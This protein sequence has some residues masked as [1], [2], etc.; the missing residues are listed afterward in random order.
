M[1]RNAQTEAPSLHQLMLVQPDGHADAAAVVRHASADAPA[2]GLSTDVAIEHWDDLFNAV[3]VRL[4]TA[5]VVPADDSANAQAA[6]MSTTVLECV[7]ALE[8]LHSTLAH[9]VDRRQRYEREAAAARAELA[10]ARAELAG[11]RASEEQ[12]R[13]QALHDSLTSL[14][15]RAYF[16]QR[17]KHAVIE[18][19]RG[20]SALA[21]LYLDL[22]GFKSINDL[23]G[24]ETG[25][26]VLRIVAARLV[27]AVRGEDMVS[28][29]GGDE[30][31]C[32]LVGMPSREQLSHLA[33]KLFD[34]VMAPLRIGELRLT[35]RPSIGI[36]TYPTDGCSAGAL[37]ST[38]D[39]AMYR[40][41]RCESGY[42]FFDDRF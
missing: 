26:E 16:E 15:N 29:I 42:E 6:R 13:H 18:A 23:H 10:R 25:D 28:R 7:Q 27:Q 12:A 24:H 36:A 22:D 11:T 4:S 40:A 5:C 20:G 37:L 41:K 19:A 2:R 30:F 14:P 21:L 39:A 8:Q 9:E 38:A 32:V 3:K 31:A 1:S 35:V 33:C 17:L 34:A